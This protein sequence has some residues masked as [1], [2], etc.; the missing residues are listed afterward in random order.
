[1][2]VFLSFAASAECI[3]SIDKENIY[4]CG[5]SAKPSVDLDIRSGVFYIDKQ[6]VLNCS[7]LNLS[8]ENVKEIIESNS[9]YFKINKSSDNSH[10]L[11]INFRIR[12][13]VIGR[14]VGDEV[15]QSAES[16]KGYGADIGTVVGGMIGAGVGSM[17]AGPGGGVVATMITAGMG[18]LGGSTESS[19]SNQQSDPS[20]QAENWESKVHK[21]D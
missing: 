9:L 10:N 16:D 6:P 11:S 1:M 20:Q 21:A 5:Y 13:G 2:F 17:I 12:G 18:G 19:S 4:C 3:I 8:P 7:T 14:R 15:D